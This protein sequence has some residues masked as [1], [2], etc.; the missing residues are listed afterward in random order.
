[1]S[2]TDFPPVSTYFPQAEADIEAVEAFRE[3]V[4]TPKMEIGFVLIRKY[5]IYFGGISDWVWGWRMQETVL[6]LLETI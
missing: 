5:L 6:N 3:E 4:V 2:A 1:M